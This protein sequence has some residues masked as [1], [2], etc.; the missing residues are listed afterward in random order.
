MISPTL[1]LLGL[2]FIGVFVV[3]FARLLRV[4][5]LPDDTRAVRPCYRA[6]NLVARDPQR[7]KVHLYDYTTAPRA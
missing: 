3:S 6:A 2:I 7:H 1:W 4:L 5:L